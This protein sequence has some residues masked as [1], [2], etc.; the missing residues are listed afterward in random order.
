MVGC[1]IF[2]GPEGKHS[3]MH[4]ASYRQHPPRRVVTR[5]T[6]GLLLCLAGVLPW[7]PASATPAR[8]ARPRTQRSPLPE[9]ERAEPQPAPARLTPA[10]ATARA[11]NRWQAT[12][13]GFTLR[14]PRHLVT[15]TA[16]G[17]QVTA[18]RGGLQWHWQLTSVGTSAQPLAAVQLAGCAPAQEGHD[19][20]RYERGQDKK[21][22]RPE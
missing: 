22:G 3:P 11:I 8:V 18:R 10:Q 6:L 17:V 5:R 7:L 1:L 14:H 16:A 21:E 19:A 4:A 15:F 20:V 2:I 9:G 13:G 12:P